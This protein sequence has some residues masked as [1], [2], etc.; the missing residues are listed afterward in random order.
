MQ[1]NIEIA[2]NAG[3]PAPV[4]IMLNYASVQPIDIVLSAINNDNIEIEIN[5]GP[6]GDKGDPGISGAQAVIN[7]SDL[8][9][10][11]G[12]DAAIISAL[13]YY[14]VNDGGG[15]TFYFDDSSSEDDNGGTIIKPAAVSGAGR[16]KRFIEN[17]VYNLKWFGAKT[18]GTDCSTAMSNCL[19]AI[20]GVGV[21][22][23]NSVITVPPG[24]Y[25]F[26]S[27]IT[28]NKNVDIIGL[29]GGI[30][31]SMGTKFSFGIDVQG[32]KFF[33]EDGVDNIKISNIW[34]KGAYTGQNDAHGLWHNC[35][36]NTNNITIQGFG[37]D[38]FFPD[39]SNTGNADSGAH[40]NLYVIENL[41]HGIHP[42]GQDSNNINFYN[43]FTNANGKSNIYD[44]SFLG[45]NYY[46]GHSGFSGMI[47][48]SNSWVTHGGTYYVAIF[49]ESHSGVEP[50]VAI[51][52]QLYWQ[53]FDGVDNGAVPQPWS[54]SKTYYCSVAAAFVGASNH[55]RYDGLYTEGGQAGI[56][57]L[58]FAFGTGAPQ[59]A[60]F[61]TESPAYIETTAGEITSRGSLTVRDRANSDI[62]ASL[63]R[64]Y[65]L[66]LTGSAGNMQMKCDIDH[67]MKFFTDNST[68]NSNTRITTNSYPAVNVGRASGVIDPA[69]MIIGK[70][71]IYF[72][73]D[74]AETVIRNFGAAISIPTTGQHA[75][76]EYVMNV[77]MD[78][79]IRGWRCTA[80]GTPGTW[81]VDYINT[82]P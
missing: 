69:T 28:W 42:K 81:I 61:S 8:R 75:Q 47:A 62:S 82:S 50:G 48:G 9:G 71:G 64:E 27:T 72:I 56:I 46:G 15:G 65:G 45:N 68:V 7:I 6:K 70:G 3:S 39:T 78:N 21:G 20:P 57:S 11:V 35:R 58:G 40:Y 41:G 52:W 2:I 59:G 17:S 51:N 24:N 77:G 19:A 60:G 36:L 14:L 55:S 73:G 31:T 79:T 54:N 23:D 43:Y 18:D 29:G 22:N 66:F 30:Y 25:T 80:S 10:V 44:D 67:T 74:D 37:G 16:W 34:L 1:T 38:G 5:A 13:G 33:R 76:G 49:P 26:N 63:S 53:Q 12:Q 32:M 4:D